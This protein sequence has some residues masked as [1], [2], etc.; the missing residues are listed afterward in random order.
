MMQGPWVLGGLM[1]NQWSVG[2]WGDQA[3]NAMPLQP[4][5]NY[6]LPAGWYLTTSPILTADWKRMRQGMS[7]RCR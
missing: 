5:V 3:V 4:F 2:G 6:N 7:G 1:N